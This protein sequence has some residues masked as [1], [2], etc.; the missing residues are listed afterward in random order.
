MATFLDPRF[1]TEHKNQEEVLD[2]K[3]KV[4]REMESLSPMQGG[5]AVTETSSPSESEKDQGAWKKQRKS[6][7][8]FFKKPAAEPSF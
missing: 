1:R 7:G 2:I 3:A 6:L 8:S 4:V 5:A